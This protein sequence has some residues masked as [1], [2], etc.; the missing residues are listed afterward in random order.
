MRCAAFCLVC[1][2]FLS[3][4]SRLVR[5]SLSAFW[6]PLGSCVLRVCVFRMVLLMYQ[7]E[8]QL[9]FLAVSV[10][11]NTAVAGVLSVV[12]EGALCCQNVMSRMT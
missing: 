12:L 2:L 11:Q 9:C 3:P 7:V 6:L 5:V 10:F 1:A 8:W 4:S